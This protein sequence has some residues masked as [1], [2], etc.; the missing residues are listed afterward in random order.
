MAQESAMKP[1]LL[2]ALAPLFAFAES[3]IPISSDAVA[4]G[5]GYDTLRG[6]LRGD[7]TD[8]QQAPIPVAGEVVE[9]PLAEITSEQDLSSALNVSVSAKYGPISGAGSYIREQRINSFS[10][11]ML[12]SLR[13]KVRSESST[14]KQLNAADFATLRTDYARFREKCGDTFVL[15]RALGGEF[16]A[17]VELKTRNQQ[18]KTE[19]SAKIAGG[20]PLSGNVDAKNRVEQILKD[21]SS[22]VTVIRGGGEG[23][24]TID[25]KEL[26][27]AIL[28]FPAQVKGRPA[29]KLLTYSVVVQDYL[30]LNVPA[31]ISVA[32]FSNREKLAY[33]NEADALARRVR[34]HIADVRYLIENPEQFGSPATAPYLQAQAMHEAQ[35]RE[36]ERK[37]GGCIESRIA[38]GDFKP[39][40]WAPTG[41]PN[42]TDGLSRTELVALIDRARSALDRSISDQSLSEIA[43]LCIAQNGG[44][45]IPLAGAQG[46]AL[47]VVAEIRRRCPPNTCRP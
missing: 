6:Q 7:C 34:Q 17:I 31:N 25:S 37:I 35:L 14:P 36:L 22:K 44:A 39:P 18:D 19:V 20:G 33:I 21:R 42:R 3:Q 46:A 4:I 13:V 28:A 15:S 11:W 27:N 41:M 9:F 45:N 23:A 1:L 32:T 47:C 2:L 10:S 12:V 26:L 40:Q 43:S 16:S 8:M 29:D 30:T 38:C 5:R 24:L